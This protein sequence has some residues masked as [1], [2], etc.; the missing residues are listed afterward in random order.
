M[1]VMPEETTRK[2]KVFEV[3]RELKLET[4]RVLEVLASLGCD[5]SRKQM[6]A[7]DEESYVELLRR[8]DKT[9]LQKYQS[10]Q[11]TVREEDTKKDSARL[12]EAELEKLLA[13]KET[14]PL[15]AVP[16]KIELP[17]FKGLV[18]E[19]AAPK[20]APV[21]I[22]PEEKPAGP[23][24]AEAPAVGKVETAAKAKAQAPVAPT[25]TATP[26]APAAA[27]TPEEKPATVKAAQ[28]TKRKIELPKPM[29]LKIIEAAPAQPKL[30]LKRK[31]PATPIE[32]VDEDLKAAVDSKLVVEIARTAPPKGKPAARPAETA[33]AARR[34]KR[35]KSK[36]AA[37][38]PTGGPQ[39]AVAHGRKGRKVDQHEVAANIRKTLAAMD[40][41]SRR[42]HRRDR[43]DAAVDIAGSEV[44]K[45]T[46]FLTSGEL[47]ALMEVPVQDIIKRCLEM[48]TIVSINQRLDRD[49][50]ELLAADFG[51]DVEFVQEAAIE[52]AVEESLPANLSPRQ[53]VVT[54]MGH[55]DH[56]KTT[57]LDFLRRTRVAEG[58]AG[59]I[60]QHIGAYEVNY[61]GNPITFLDT[62]GHEAFTA[63][64]ARGAQI[65]DIV[66][67]VVA[68]DDRVMPQTLEAIDHARAA[69]VP[70]V[71][72][73][74]KVDKPTANPENIYRQLADNNLLVEKWGGKHQSAEISA[75]FGQGI[76][77]LLAE[78]LVSAEVLDLKADPTIRARGTIVES[79]LDKGLGVV[80][81]VLVEGGTLRAGDPFVAGQ[82]YGRVR[83][84]MT[85]IGTSLESAGPARPVQVIGFNGV[86]QAGDKLVVQASEK[87]AREIALK[88]QQQ[89]REMSMRQIR[90]LSLDQMSKKMAERELQELA[91]VIKGDVH[92]SVEVL[93][94][95]LQRLST[96]E[97]SVNII[98]RGVGGITE[99]D[100]L[101]AAASG[102]I[103]IGFHVHPNPQARELAR[104]EGVEIRSYRIIH[105]V[106]DDVRKAME[107]LLAPLKEEKVIGQVEIRRVFRISR[108]GSVAGCYVQ[109]G[110][111]TRNSKARL[112]RDGVEVWHGDLS[113]L[114]RFK[115]DA[116]EVVAGFEC[117]LSLEGFND[118]HEG[119][120]LEVFEI[121]EVSRKLEEV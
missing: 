66:V 48:G 98:H 112:L 12:R 120:R 103:V 105:E 39:P 100:I 85:E 81:T 16:K 42:R 64:R 40:D 92:G 7:I 121:I 41:H 11:T 104:S 44:L 74:N 56:G 111:V 80:A 27:A 30:K 8:F 10:E 79:R 90:A 117:G 43:Q 87:D 13:V 95:S 65:T 102:A 61:D 89:Y 49:T 57:L 118:I 93:A 76:D 22:L 45:V 70:I 62:P 84:L 1:Q 37:P 119:D 4:T 88:R 73:V 25:K 38:T 91:L 86:P 82:H 108:I 114:K 46:E 35:K 2:R 115:D 101:L 18:I 28:P 32:V 106:V 31:R 52:E 47:A 75:K 113:S 34:R 107:G 5:L 20:E 36:T 53:P 55:V 68:A 109:E 19:A 69:G 26:Q 72:A 110:K 59:G 6:S 14:T 50:I 29:P 60:T 24:K 21:E 83:S 15:T 96:S 33:P 3:A 54:V 9:R 51:V 78:I 63:M 67:L 97:V 17:K 116:R 94:D 77:D 99:S 23:T 58:E 71:V